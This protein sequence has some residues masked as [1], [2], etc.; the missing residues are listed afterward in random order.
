MQY[1]IVVGE[2]TPQAGGMC[3]HMDMLAEGLADEFHQV[4][5]WSPS[6]TNLG[7]ESANVDIH[8]TLGNL[9]PRY[10]RH[11]GRML[12][13]F[14]LPRRLLVYWVPHAY[15]YNSMNLAFC[16]WLWF[17]SA[18]RKDRVELMVQECFLSFTRR[19]WRQS[20]VAVVHRV[21]TMVVLR[22]AD[23]VWLALSGYEGRLK[24]FALGRRV[25][26]GWLPVP[27]TVEVVHDPARVS[28]IR[29]DMAPKGFLIG[30]FG[31]FGWPIADLLENIVPPLLRGTDAAMV[32][33]GTGG[34]EFR[35]RLLVRHPDLAPRL[36]ATGYLDDTA[37]SC[38]LSACDV[39]VQPYP[40]GLTARRSSAL[41]P[42]AHGR[43]VVTNA[44]P[45][46]EPLWRESGAVVFAPA[47][48]A[49]FL[50]AVRSL[51]LNPAEYQRVSAAASE[52]YGDYFEP[53]QMVK[54]IRGDA[55]PVH[56]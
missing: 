35:E 49:G 1:H 55:P 20:A 29:A 45:I 6:A 8:K 41:A 36:Y 10:L 4:H 47:T 50:N 46:T 9:S 48:G 30:H 14:P 39:M 43:P 51:R 18:W 25:S 54:I 53:A 56:A 26:F 38:F 24:P 44:S 31:T 34:A 33:L 2:S 3:R 28:K 52:T 15:G 17:R 23:Q 40:D 21:M 19:S 16:L 27:S 7:C 13:A 22:A 32:L 37:L 11:T 5:V 12:N 42:M